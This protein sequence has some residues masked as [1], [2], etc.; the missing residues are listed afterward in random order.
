MITGAS[1]SGGVFDAGAAGGGGWN[2]HR[3][4]RIIRATG[5]RGILISGT[6]Q[7]FMALVQA[8]LCQGVIT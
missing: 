6:T 8:T 7:P 1:H 5:R 3:H 4:R 2:H